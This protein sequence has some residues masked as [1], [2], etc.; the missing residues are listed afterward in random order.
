MHPNRLGDVM[1]ARAIG[2]LNDLSSACAEIDAIVAG[3]VGH[4]RLGV[5]PFVTP[6]LISTTLRELERENVQLV[7][8]IHKKNEP[9]R[10]G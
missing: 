9:R 7:M 6:T 8:E 3:R 4:L 1:L 5:I 2:V 10:S